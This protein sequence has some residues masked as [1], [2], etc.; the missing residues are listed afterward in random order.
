MQRV[1]YEHFCGPLAP[2]MHTHHICNGPRNCVSPAHLLACSPKEHRE[3]HHSL[4]VVTKEMSPE[5]KRLALNARGR[6]LARE[7]RTRD[8][9]RV[10][11]RERAARVRHKARD[12]EGFRA[13]CH[14]NYRRYYQRLKEGRVLKRPKAGVRTGPYIPRL[15]L[16][17]EDLSNVRAQHRAY[18]AT[19]LGTTVLG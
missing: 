1:F 18:Y 12:P 8:P 9:E 13:R 3:F 4:K 6:F 16:S 5:Q 11:A 7:R 15:F 10:R 17:P 19:H 14:A 2:E